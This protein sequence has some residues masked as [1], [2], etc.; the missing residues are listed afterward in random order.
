MKN[1]IHSDSDR[2]CIVQSGYEN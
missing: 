1:L 2:E